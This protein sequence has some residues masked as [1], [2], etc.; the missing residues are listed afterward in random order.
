M[1]TQNKWREARNKTEIAAVRL[2][3]YFFIFLLHSFTFI[4]FLVWSRTR[5][6]VET[7]HS[8]IFRYLE[9]SIGRAQ[10][11]PANPPNWRYEQGVEGC[12][13]E[14]FWI[15]FWPLITELTIFSQRDRRSW[16]T[17]LLR[18]RSEES[19]DSTSG[20]YQDKNR[21]RLTKKS[22]CFLGKCDEIV[23]GRGKRERGST[24]ETSQI[25]SGQTLSSSDDSIREVG[26]KML[27]LWSVLLLLSVH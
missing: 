10:F 8:F 2:L 11:I 1:Q 24:Q 25:E 9:T 19:A 20:N 14:V 13:G 23:A 6:C 18:G 4:E 27:R 22:E 26:R 5:A 17:S 7:Y 21:Y 15:L 3:F 16:A 12:T